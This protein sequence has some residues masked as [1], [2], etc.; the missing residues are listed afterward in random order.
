MTSQFEPVAARNAFPC[1]DEPA[2]R[3]TFTTTLKY[4]ARFTMTRSNG[5]AETTST[6][7][8]WTIT[9]FSTTP[10]M[11]VYLNAFLVSDLQLTSVTANDVILPGEVFP[12]KKS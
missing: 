7:G 2:F 5:Q 11:P 4:P 12:V 9:K 10:S 6:E 8:P 1:F 3:S